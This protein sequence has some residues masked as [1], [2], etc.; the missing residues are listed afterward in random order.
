RVRAL[1]AALAHQPSRPPHEVV[2]AVEYA[3]HVPAA[4]HVMYLPYAAPA[5]GAAQLL[6][7]LPRALHQRDHARMAWRGGER[8]VGGPAP[9]TGH[10]AQRAAL[11]Q[12]VDRGQTSG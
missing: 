2:T 12:Q 6:V 3:A 1:V 5:L 4:E 9:V 7:V 10:R 8:A 11:H